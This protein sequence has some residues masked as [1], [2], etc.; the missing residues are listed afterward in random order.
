MQGNG[1]IKDTRS[2][3]KSKGN[4]Q[5]VQHNAILFEP[6]QFQVNSLKVKMT[7]P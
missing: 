5:M 2:G 4:K 7:L 6:K 1:V 3:K